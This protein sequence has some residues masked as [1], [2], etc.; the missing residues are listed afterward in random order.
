MGSYGSQLV[1]KYASDI[2]IKYSKDFDGTELVSELIC[3][4]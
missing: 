1:K 2:A 4:N 3:F